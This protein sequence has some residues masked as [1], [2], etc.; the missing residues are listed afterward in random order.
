MTGRQ[1]PLPAST[2][3][4]GSPPQAT[5]VPPGFADRVMA[6][7]AGEPPP[8]LAGTLARS[9]VRL[10]FG[11]ARAVLGVAWRLA[12][13]RSRPVVPMVRLQ[14]LLLV[15]LLAVILGAG[16]AL[17]AGGTLRVIQEAQRSVGA[18]PRGP[19]AEGIGTGPSLAPDGASLVRPSAMPGA[20][21]RARQERGTD[22]GQQEAARR[23]GDEQ[24][25]AD[26]PPRRQQGDATEGGSQQGGQ[27]GTSPR[28]GSAQRTEARRQTPAPGGGR[29]QASAEPGGGSVQAQPSPRGR[30]GSRSGG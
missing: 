23:E 5:V 18:E 3:G 28:D 11:D 6:R 8:S 19:A 25:P 27:Q 17:A 12:F 16:G 29:A 30:G 26:E 20:L 24:R 21:E 1:V 4:L 15:L 14:S 7:V 13:A 22:R 10:R 9:L 2:S